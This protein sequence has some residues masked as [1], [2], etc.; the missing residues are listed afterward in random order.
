MKYHVALTSATG[1]CTT[2]FAH[3][4]VA[5]LHLDPSPPSSHIQQ[6]WGRLPCALHG[7]CR[8]QIA[9]HHPLKA[10]QRMCHQMSHAPLTSGQQGGGWL[11][12]PVGGAPP[13]LQQEAHHPQ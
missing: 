11:A 1:A 13:K 2:T 3:H 4:I 12:R 9:A 10:V 5:R 6:A 8:P 7:G